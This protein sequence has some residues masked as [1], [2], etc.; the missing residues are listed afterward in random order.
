MRHNQREKLAMTTYSW[1]TGH[2]A[3]S[4]EPFATT[5]V[6]SSIGE[7]PRE[8]VDMLCWLRPFRRSRECSESLV[9]RCQQNSSLHYSPVSEFLPAPGM[10]GRVR[11]LRTQN[12]SEP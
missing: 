3:L 11:G 8:V 4:A 9:S 1:V 12:S 2:G 7:R 10:T 6:E 5:Y